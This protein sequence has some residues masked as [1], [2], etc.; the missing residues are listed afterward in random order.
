MYILFLSTEKLF[1]IVAY[2]QTLTES[3]FVLVL[4]NASIFAA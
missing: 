1:Q 3:L 2:A 4:G